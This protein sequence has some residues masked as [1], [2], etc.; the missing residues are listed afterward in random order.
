MAT[1]QQVVSLRITDLAFALF[2]AREIKETEEPAFEGL[3]DA[4][5]MSKETVEVSAD[6]AKY[7]FWM[8]RKYGYRH[9]FHDA[10]YDHGHAVGSSIRAACVPIGIYPG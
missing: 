5:F 8:A 10:R 2:A 3:L 1:E 7:A 4:T 6:V 9:G